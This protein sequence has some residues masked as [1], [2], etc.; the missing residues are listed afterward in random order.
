MRSSDDFAR[1][2]DPLFLQLKGMIRR[3]A[4]TLTTKALWQL[5]GFRMPDGSTETMTVEPFTGIGIY[6]RPPSST[7]PQA[8]VVMVG[9]AKSPA[10][11]AVRDEQ[12]RAAAIAAIAP[13]G[14]APDE[15]ALFNSQA[16]L[17]IKADGTLEAR[18]VNGTA[19]ALALKSDVDNLAAY[20]DGTSTVPSERLI[21]S[22]S[23]AF[24]SGAVGGAPPS[25]GTK[26][27]K[28]E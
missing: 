22:V 17:Y 13:N 28:G 7:Q 25:T 9:D 2:T 8:I 19:V 4:I 5:A 1:D 15:T 24:A 27:L 18:S 23:G 6:A 12:T 21:L 26:K 3:M 11:I 20:V 10:I 16:T 14:F